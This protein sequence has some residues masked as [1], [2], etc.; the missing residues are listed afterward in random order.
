M[1]RALIFL[2]LAIYS[3]KADVLFRDAHAG[4]A[5]RFESDQKRVETT[6]TREEVVELALYWATNFYRDKSLE[7]AGLKF[8]IEPLRFW[9]VTFKKSHTGEAFYVVVLPDGIIVEPQDEKR[10]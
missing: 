4:H 9:L 10:I 1:R 5:Y 6:V 3:G 2:L 8:K 7:F